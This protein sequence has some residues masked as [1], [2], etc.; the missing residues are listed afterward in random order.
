MILG[1][2][3]YYWGQ[4]EGKIKK[5]TPICKEETRELLATQDNL[6]PGVVMEEALME[7]TSKHRKGKVTRTACAALQRTNCN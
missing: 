2:I 7:V 6:I 4:G 5:I 1:E 3:F